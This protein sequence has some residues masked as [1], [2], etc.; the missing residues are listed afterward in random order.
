MVGIKR[1]IGLVFC[2][3]FYRERLAILV[4]QINLLS[5]LYFLCSRKI[6]TVKIAFGSGIP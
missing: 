3:N 2:S 1:D 6:A 5:D 4:L